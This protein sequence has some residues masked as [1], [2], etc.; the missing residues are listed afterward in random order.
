VEVVATAGLS[1]GEHQ[2][3]LVTIAVCPA[4][5]QIVAF[6]GGVPRR[7]GV[8]AAPPE[9]FEAP[10]VF[11]DEIP[12]PERQVVQAGDDLPAAVFSAKR[13]HRWRWELENVGH[14]PESV[15]LAVVLERLPLASWTRVV[16]IHCGAVA[17][18]FAQLAVIERVLNATEGEADAEFASVELIATVMTLQFN[19]EALLEE[20]HAATPLL[21]GRS[22][23]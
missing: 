20:C 11:G 14:E 8:R 18:A 10:D 19:V 23:S 12:F 7:A 22:A 5:D 3:R 15:D 17:A 21:L 2:W 9:H 4:S 16:Q 6:E 13:D 1:I